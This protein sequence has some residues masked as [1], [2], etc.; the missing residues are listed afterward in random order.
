[1]SIHWSSVIELNP[2]RRTG[3]A[4]TLL[5]S[6]SMGPWPKAADDEV[7]RAV[8]GGE[9]DRDGVDVAVVLEVG[10]F[11]CDGARAGGDVGAFGDEGLG[12]GEADAAPGAG[13]EGVLSCELKVHVGWCSCV[14]RGG[15]CG[16]CVGRRSSG[17][18]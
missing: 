1:M 18:W 5:T 7:W 6:T 3:A 4:P 15:R 16:G 13:D 12:D 10:E 8:G 17:R 2:S 14:V 9:V 11:G